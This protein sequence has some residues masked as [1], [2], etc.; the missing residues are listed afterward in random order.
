MRIDLDKVLKDK[1]PNM[2]PFLARIMG[3]YLKKII[4]QDELNR[5]IDSKPGATGLEFARAALEFLD[6]TY[7]T[8]GLDKI[9]PDGRYI[10]ASNHPFGGLDGVMLAEIISK[11]FYNVRLIVNDVL[12]NIPQLCPVLV[13]VNKFG[14]QKPEYVGL[15]KDAMS[16]NM[17]MVTFPAGLCSRR[18][19][20]VV[21]DTP[22]KNSFIKNAIEYNRDIVPIYFDGKLSNFFYRLH[23]LRTKLGIKANIEML[24]LADEMLKQRGQKFDVYFGEPI[25]AE[26]I[27]QGGSPREWCEKVR[28]EVYKLKK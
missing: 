9:D 1:R 13:P 19:K 24:Y 17:P 4:H 25:T 10:F 26:Q 14:K 15:H 6:I 5:L 20:G 11:R 21:T 8:H 16:S 2:S 18:T 12:M 7:T 3:F 23:N 27:K 22:W 28:S